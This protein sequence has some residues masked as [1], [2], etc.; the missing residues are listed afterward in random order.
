MKRNW[1]YLGTNPICRF[2]SLMLAFENLNMLT[3]QLILH[4]PVLFLFLFLFVNFKVI[5]S[6]RVHLAKLGLVVQRI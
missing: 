1:Y 6:T 3:K 4:I 5:I 2:Y